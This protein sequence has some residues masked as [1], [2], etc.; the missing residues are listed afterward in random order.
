MQKN[1]AKKKLEPPLGRLG[2]KPSMARFGQLLVDRPL[3]LPIG[4]LTVRDDSNRFLTEAQPIPDSRGGSATAI[5]GPFPHD[6]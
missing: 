1:L 3:F 4:A 5:I 2:I 6:P